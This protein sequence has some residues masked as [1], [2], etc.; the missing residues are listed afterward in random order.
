MI[1]KSPNQNQKHLF[2]SNLAEFINPQHELCLLADEID[3]RQFDAD[4]APFYAE[5]GCPA[6]PVRLMVGLLIVKQLYNLGEET[7]MA[8][9]VSNP[10]FHSFCGESVFQWKFPCDPS[11][12]VHFRHRIGVEGVERILAVSI[13]LHGEEILDEDVSID[14]TVQE[15]NIT[16][17]TDTKQAVKI[18]RKCRQIA[19]NEGVKQRQSYRRVVKDLLKKANAKSQQKAKEKKKARKKL[20]TIASRVVRELKRKLSADA[21]HK[22]EEK[23]E[24]Y[25]Q[26]LNQ[27]K[28]SPKKIYL[29]HAPEAAC[30][31]KGKEHKKYE[32]GSKVTFAVGQLSNVFKAAVSF[33]GNPNDNQRL[34]KT[35]EQQKRLTGASPKRAFTDRGCRSQKIG[36][37][38]I[39]VPSNGVGLSAAERTRL[40]K[41]FRR[42]AGIEPIIGHTKSDFGLE[43]QTI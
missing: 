35:L 42:R 29:M 15:K 27:T 4:F 28:D 38:E 10:Y 39:I 24:L 18:I 36:E 7:V 16:Y 31:A 9:G 1:G 41:S 8:E 34:E 23:L 22:H 11:D 13:F 17:P 32:F 30:I 26:V 5:V 40:R 25:E 2:L 6:K 33:R 3:W 43:S 21:V 20:K 12:L 14:T 19:K 37:T